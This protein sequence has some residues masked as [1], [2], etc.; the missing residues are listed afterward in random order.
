MHPMP[1]VTPHHLN[2]NAVL[3]L[4]VGIS[5]AELVTDGSG[6]KAYTTMVEKT[7]CSA[8]TAA[9]SDTAAVVLG[10]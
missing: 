10:V 1:K 2:Y 6:I 9:R 4:P 5:S 8:L 3:L 7:G